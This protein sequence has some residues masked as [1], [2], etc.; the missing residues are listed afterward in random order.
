MV[1]GIA[2]PEE[3]F[4]IFFGDVLVSPHSI[5][6]SHTLFNGL[7]FSLC[8][9]NNQRRNCSKC[10]RTYEARGQVA[11]PRVPG[12]ARI[13]QPII[14]TAFF[15]PVAQKGLSAISERKLRRTT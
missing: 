8:M 1:A 2:V 12:R 9:T 7:R 14:V 10:R 3:S 15:L 4:V 13:A 11:E 6:F 5:S